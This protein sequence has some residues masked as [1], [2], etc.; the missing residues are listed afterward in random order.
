MDLVSGLVGEA[1]EASYNFLSL[2]AGAASCAVHMDAPSAKW[3][4]DICI[5]QSRLWTIEV[6][7]V[8]P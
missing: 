4:L 5:D 8:V 3:T 2:Y 7:D 1:V 6:S